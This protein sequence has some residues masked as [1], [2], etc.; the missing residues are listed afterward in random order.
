MLHWTLLH[1]LQIGSGSPFDNDFLSYD[2]GTE[3]V[4]KFM[5]ISTNYAEG[6]W[7]LDYTQGILQI[8]SHNFFQ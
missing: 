7:E 2:V 8:C 1:N 3:F 4:P 6:E 5:A